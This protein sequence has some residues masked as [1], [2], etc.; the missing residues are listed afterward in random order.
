[1][2]LLIMRETTPGKYEALKV[3]SLAE[4]APMAPKCLLIVDVSRDP[5]RVLHD[6]R[7]IATPYVPDH[8][9][10]EGWVR[11]FARTLLE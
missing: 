9:T 6:R 3:A 1:M 2:L 10:L 7:R 11:A 4:V 5:M 8:R